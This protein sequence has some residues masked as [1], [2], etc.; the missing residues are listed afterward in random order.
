MEVPD[1]VPLELVDEAR[2]VR[3]AEQAALARLID[4][5]PDEFLAKLV[6]TGFF[7]AHDLSADDRADVVRAVLRFVLPDVFERRT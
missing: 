5:H 2:R 3:A 1:F 7:D 6:E 4:E